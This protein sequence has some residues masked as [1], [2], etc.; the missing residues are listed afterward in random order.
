MVE[1]KDK[2]VRLMSQDMA[3]GGLLARGIPGGSNMTD[4]PTMEGLSEFIDGKLSRKDRE[5]VV[6]HLSE[7]G[8]CYSILSESL[9]IHEEL[10]SRS[11]ARIKRY[12]SYT[13]PTA[14]AA[15]A[16]ILF[17]FR[18]LQPEY[19]FSGKMKME[20]EPAYRA[21]VI[22][23]KP[24][25]KPDVAP[26]Y[27]S[28]AGELADRLSGNN[29]A[30][31][32]AR[33]AG[34]QRKPATAYGFSAVVPLE[35]TAFRIGVCLTALEVSL[36][37]KDQEKIEAFSKKLIE[38]LKPMEST[39][40]P[41]PTIIEQK[42]NGNAGRE[43]SRHE[44]FSSAVEASFENTQEAVFLKFGEWVEAAGLAAE[45]R[46]AA[47]FQPVVVS[48]FRQDMETRG[49]PVGTLKNLSHLES[50]ITSGKI[51]TEDFTNMVQLLA[52]CK[53]MF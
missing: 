32:L 40:G 52:D 35:K 20:P 6:A 2:K 14:L 37:A 10:I 19:E 21:E 31:S 48:G 29:N 12:L 47:F 11:R 7:C 51:G 33:I 23:K 53:E 39:Y 28:F 30:A 3:L 4:C 42:G 25:L 36:K 34:K 9:T 46:D 49:A 45:V 38:L 8:R 24:S 44:G 13:I 16:V 50:I 15:A 41:M 22:D 43:T 18:I 27:H 26:G 17:I 5:R 1:N